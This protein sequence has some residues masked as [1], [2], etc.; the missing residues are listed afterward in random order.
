MYARIYGL[1]FVLFFN[2]SWSTYR[3]DGYTHSN[4]LLPIDM[5]IGGFVVRNIE[6]EKNKLS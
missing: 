4:V 3:I 2:S 1:Y 5:I 6:A